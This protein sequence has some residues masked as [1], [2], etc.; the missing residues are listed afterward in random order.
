VVDG[1]VFIG[2]NDGNVYALDAGNGSEQ[3][4]FQAGD[5][6]SSSPTVVDETVFVGSN[7]NN[8]YALDAGDGTEQ[9]RFQ[10]GDTV[11]SSPTVVDGTVFVGSND[12]NMYALDAGD[13]TE[14]WRFEI[15][16]GRSS[17]T[18]VDGTVFVGGSKM[19]ALD[20]GD[21]TE[22]WHFKPRFFA[23]SSP[24][25]VDE[26]VF[27]ADGVIRDIAGEYYFYVLDA[28]DGTEQWRFATGGGRSSPTVVDGT[29]FVGGWN[30]N[31][32]ALDAGVEES[33][34]GSRVN[35]GTLGH[36]HVWAG[37]APPS[38]GDVSL[39]LTITDATAEA[40]GTATVTYI[41]TN[42]GNTES[43]GLQGEID[44]PPG[45][46]QLGESG[47]FTSL[48]PG[49][50]DSVS[51]EVLVPESA[52]G[53]Y[54]IDG[55][56]TDD[57]GNE[58][59]ASATITVEEAGEPE[60]ELTADGDETAP[61]GEAT[62]SLELSNIGTATAGTVGIQ[63]G[64]QAYD[65]NVATTQ[66]DGGMW[67]E[68]DRYW[69]IDDLAS[70]A[71]R[72]PSITF[73]IPDTISPGEYVVDAEAVLPSSDYEVLAEATAT[74][75]ISE[76]N[77]PPNAAF[78]VT[79]ED[80]TVGDTLT[81]DA[82]ESNDPDGTIET[83][84]WKVG[85]GD[86]FT[87]EGPEFTAE[88][89]EGGEMTV[90]LRVTDDDNATDTATQ[91]VVVQPAGVTVTDA[92]EDPVADAEV[93]VYVQEDHS[94]SEA[95]TPDMRLVNETETD[96]N[97][98]FIPPTSFNSIDQRVLITAKKGDWFSV[99]AESVDDIDDMSD[100]SSP[101][102]NKQMLVEPTVARVDTSPDNDPYGIV[103]VWRTVILPKP[104]TS[105]ISI[106]VTDV[107]ISSGEELWDV[108][109]V[110]ALHGLSAGHFFLSTPV[111]ATIRQSDSQIKV[112]HPPG[113]LGTI[114]PYKDRNPPIE[115]FHP[116][117]DNSNLPLY[118]TTR[119]LNG[120]QLIDTPSKYPGWH[121]TTT[122]Q[123]EEADEF[124][125]YIQTY[126]DP[127]L[128][129]GPI[130]GELCDKTGGC[131]SPLSVMDY[132][133]GL[134]DLLD[135]SRTVAT[136][137]RGVN[138]S[139]HPDE[140]P[141]DR[142]VHVQAWEESLP[143]IYSDTFETSVVGEFE[144]TNVPQTRPGSQELTRFSV[145]SEW[146]RQRN[147][148]GIFSDTFTFGPIDVTN[149]GAVETSPGE[150]ASIDAWI[151]NR[152]LDEVIITE[153]A[154]GG[155]P[156]TDEITDSVNITLSPGERFLYN[157]SAD[158][159]P[160][161]DT[162][163]EVTIEVTDAN[164]NTTLTSTTIE[165]N[166]NTEMALMTESAMLPSETTG[167][168]KSVNINTGGDSVSVRVAPRNNQTYQVG[169]EATVAVNVTNEQSDVAIQYQ[170]EEYSVSDGEAL[171][172]LN[173]PGEHDMIVEF[174]DY[175][176]EVTITV[177]ESNADNS[178][179]ESN[180]DSGD[181]SGSSGNDGDDNDGTTSGNGDSGDDR[182]T[183]GNDDSSGPGFGP[184]AVLAGL[185]GAGYLL[186]R[187]GTDD[188]DSS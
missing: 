117:N 129:D 76:D 64:G 95:T 104:N 119:F 48:G 25:V 33:S 101:R 36:H 10:T 47:S 134:L 78:T 1:T 139:Y 137:G 16:V 135:G 127:M 75:T 12:N 172:P 93:K 130:T 99:S 79:P 146:L 38:G 176:R 24:T 181:D 59:S 178:S 152:S 111:G 11:L 71:S 184:G 103:S 126:T 123:S 86:T 188:T 42:E 106:E 100:Y 143:Y 180:G 92:D 46:W 162:N 43:T 32:Y 140:F 170:G 105:V 147:N 72:S 49:E 88:P 9:W 21:G 165:V 122:E 55:S 120:M 149:S 169:G 83:Y 113:P 144:V 20:A 163:Q 151:H 89:S 5:G 37:T 56:V 13:G 112:T 52:S 27:V 81:L 173:E 53:E 61:G 70:G 57:A 145:E 124:A 108:D 109:Y 161:Q 156:L 138:T 6:V 154:V 14:Q 115:F 107:N 44:L 174:N 133:D 34:E 91:T 167:T 50:S 125:E 116:S 168:V 159:S 2:S 84:E 17:P 8:T 54:T 102:L 62:V 15:G 128:L 132:L 166:D 157:T 73:E 30:T 7:D 51:A 177:E 114:D 118:P 187:R 97:G 41:L 65:W 26:T 182:D 87:P 35:L 160:N 68:H 4:R 142:E 40:G 18:V 171:L 186:K 80:P 185:G 29:V 175:E 150:S 153:V 131:F 90:K 179:N 3:W 22:Q 63:L 28:S 141:A 66:T 60:F 136:A 98:Q 77:T 121:E 164:Q 158:I 58:A 39:T 31:V 96:S 183:S 23:D 82:S 94:E 85:D 19:Y 67:Y 69:D 74:V 155:E 148:R 45:N 110:S